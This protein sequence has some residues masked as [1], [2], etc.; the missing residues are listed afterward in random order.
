MERSGVGALAIIDGIHLLGIVTDRDLVRR[1]LACAM[2]S[3]ARVD[4]VMSSP[5]V[6]IAAEPA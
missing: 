4:G 1:A 5:V 3:D 6:T 2:P